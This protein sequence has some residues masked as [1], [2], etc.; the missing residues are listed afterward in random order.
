VIGVGAEVLFYIR[1]DLVIHA[2]DDMANKAVYILADSYGTVRAKL[3]RA[4]PALPH[5]APR[6]PVAHL[7][8]VIRP[9]ATP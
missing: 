5:P 4:A 2:V 8:R 3:P 1:R 6:T 9:F 7:A